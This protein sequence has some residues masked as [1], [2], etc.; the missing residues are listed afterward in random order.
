MKLKS[1]SM[2]IIFYYKKII[3][4]LRLILICFFFILIV[5]IRNKNIIFKSKAQEN[6]LTLKIKLQ[7]IR[8]KGA[9]HLVKIILYNNQG[10]VREYDNVNF[11]T[12]DGQNYSA[13]INLGNNFIFSQSYAFFIKPKNYLGKIFCA[14]RITGNNCQAP[15]IFI[16][17]QNN[18]IDFS[19]ERILSG[20]VEPQDGKINSYDISKIISELGKNNNLKTDINN[21]GIVNVVDYSLVLWGLAHNITNDDEIKIQFINATPTTPLTQTPET[22]ITSIQN[23]PT[24]SNTPIPTSSTSPILTPTPT[25]IINQSGKCEMRISG[26]IYI[27]APLI[28]RQC[29]VLNEANYYCVNNPSDCNVSSCLQTT[30]KSIKENVRTCSNGMATFDESSPI[31]CSVQFIPATNCQNPPP[32]NSCDDNKPRC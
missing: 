25:P 28:G 27:N 9:N 15:Q 26:K 16:N 2:K 1:K 20:D 32:Y 24:P 13:T 17:N 14:P 10:K 5:L 23:T 30:K 19:E 12:Q 11:I 29:R 31:E 6:N 18:Y 22:T 8:N 4:P 7:G 3:Y 21:D